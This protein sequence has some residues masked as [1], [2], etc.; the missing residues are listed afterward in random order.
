[1]INR[2]K[3]LD[4]LRKVIGVSVEKTCARANRS[5]TTFHLADKG[6]A[7]HDTVKLF[8]DA[9]DDLRREKIDELKNLN[10]KAG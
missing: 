7:N 4:P 9:L 8:L 2:I 10:C 1:M 5:K 3:I 6:E